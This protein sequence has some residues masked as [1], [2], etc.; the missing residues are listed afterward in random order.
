MAAKCEVCGNEYDKTFSDQGAYTHLH[1]RAHALGDTYYG[2][3]PVS[4]L[5]HTWWFPRTYP[6]RLR[7][8]RRR[9]LPA[10]DRTVR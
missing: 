2:A 7:P 5:H 8:D 6:R 4:G 3:P 10:E 9:R 1:R